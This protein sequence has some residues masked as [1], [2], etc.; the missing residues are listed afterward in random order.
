MKHGQPDLNNELDCLHRTSFEFEF[1]T[2]SA[3]NI[4]RM[5]IDVKLMFSVNQFI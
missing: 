3:I 2:L 1:Y 4:L 5:E